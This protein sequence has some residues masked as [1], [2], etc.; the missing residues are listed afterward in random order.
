MGEEGYVV[1]ISVSTVVMAVV[2]MVVM[3]FLLLLLLLLLVDLELF[4][5]EQRPI[6]H[7]QGFLHFGHCLVAQP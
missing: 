6:L 4:L 1:P 5:G 2:A 7:L 3:F